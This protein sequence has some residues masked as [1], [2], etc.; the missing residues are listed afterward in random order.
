[1][2]SSPVAVALQ[3]NLLSDEALAAFNTVMT[4]ETFS[5]ADNFEKSAPRTDL[6]A[7]EKFK[8]RMLRADLPLRTSSRDPIQHYLRKGL[9]RFWYYLSVHK[10]RTGDEEQSRRG[11]LPTVIASW[12]RTYQNTARVAEI[13]TRFTIAMVAGASLVVPLALL[14]WQQSQGNR[15]LIVVICIAIFCFMIALLS[16]ASNYESMAATA[17]YAAVLTVFLS[18]SPTGGSSS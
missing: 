3:T 6:H 17:A 2:V 8:T 5:L 9:R 13:V 18:N 4:M 15:F 16:K 11:P 7:F 10:L 14:S 1:M 12:D